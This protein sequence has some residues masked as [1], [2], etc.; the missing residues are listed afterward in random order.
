MA[1]ELELI[2]VEAGGGVV[3]AMDGLREG[4]DEEFAGAV[5]AR[6]EQVAADAAVVAAAGGN[7]DVQIGL[8]VFFGYV[9]D[10]VCDFHLLRE[11]LVD[12]LHRGGIQIA[13]CGVVGGAKAA[14]FAGEDI[15]LAAESG[16]SFHY[17]NMVVKAK[18][19]VA[20]REFFVRIHYLPVFIRRLPAFFL[21]GQTHEEDG[22]ETGSD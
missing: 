16:K 7:V 17:L 8:A 6:R 11:G 1:A 15:L 18:N 20:L 12:V 21:V 10:Q 3:A 4:L 5:D 19:I 13:E 2:H 14:D 22:Q 9:A